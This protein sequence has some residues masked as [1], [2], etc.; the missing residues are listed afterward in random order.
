M[1]F[2]KI[3]YREF[4]FEDLDDLL[5]REGYFTNSFESEE[6]ISECKRDGYI[7]YYPVTTQEGDSFIEGLFPIVI[8]F[9]VNIDC[10]LDETEFAFYIFV[11]SINCL[12]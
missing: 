2:N 9:S 4:K 3:L 5:V 10:G 12:V 11:S 8:N 1:D 6:F 7:I